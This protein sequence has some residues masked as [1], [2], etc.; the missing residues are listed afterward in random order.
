MLFSYNADL[1]PRLRMTGHIRYSQPWIH[2]A[3]RLDE[4]VLYV[5]REG[6]MYLRENGL[7]Y[8][9]K[10]GDF[11]LLEPGLQHVGTRKA[12]CDYFYT[13]FTHPELRRVEDGAAAMAELAEKRRQSLISYNLDAADPTDSVTYLPKHFHLS[14]GEHRSLLRSA[15]ACYEAREEHYKRRAS[16]FLHSFLLQTA[17]EHLMAEMAVRDR[18]L[19]RLRPPW[20]SSCSI[21]TETTP[22]SSRAARYRSALR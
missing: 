5:I 19:N 20:T 10:A 16:T 4:Y 21:S 13:H 7:E 14:G 1:L 22:R 12:S 15:V 6:N 8:H 3:R 11:F 2:F 18:R 17:H 9:L